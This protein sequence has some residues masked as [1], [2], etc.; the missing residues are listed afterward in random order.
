MTRRRLPWLALVVAAGVALHAPSLRTGFYVDDYVHQLALEGELAL[1]PWAL[2]D[3]GS[4][5]DW[6]SPEDDG[7]SLPWWTSPDWRIRFFRPLSSLA[8]WLEHA[9]FGRWAP[10]Y[11]L[12]SLTLHA[13]LLVL[14]HAWMCALGLARGPALGA[15]AL[16]AASGATLVPVGWIANQNALLEVL[17]TTAAALVARRGRGTASVAVALALAAG[18]VLAKESGVAALVLL[19]WIWITG[20]GS[21]TA[22][23]SAPARLSAPTARAGAAAAALLAIGYAAFLVAAGYG[24]KSAF[25]ATPWGG[26]AEL[27]R[28]FAR[29]TTLATAGGLALVTPFPLDIV[30]WRTELAPA[31][32]ALGLALV[33]PLAVWTA[34]RVRGHPAAVPLFVWL[35]ATLLVQGAAPASDRLLLGPAVASSGLLALAI[36][37]ARERGPRR[38]RAVARLLVASAGV[39]SALAVVAQG[40]VVSRLAA[41]TRRTV[42]AADVGPPQLGRRDALVMQ[43]PS[44]LLAFSAAATWA[45][46]S[47]D[48][49]VR[50][51]IFQAGRR[52]F[53]WTREDER[54]L[55]V[56]SADEPFLTGP[57]EIV[58]LADDGSLATGTRWRTSFFDVEVLEAEDRGLRAVRLR[59]TRPLDARVRL[60]VWRDERFVALEPPAPGASASVPAVVAPALAPP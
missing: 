35:V 27:A 21:R 1:E 48:R 54:T 45:V 44:G 4:A 9:T 32:G 59:F 33:A 19:A 58:Y 14:V 42:L 34:R 50:F 3:F 41:E 26:P 7:G 39:A 28:Y 53:Q 12:A 29:L 22:L 40:I 23:P 8:L 13:L 24:T 20:A 17:L 38:A 60:L 37:R 31:V 25:Y 56:R 51:A 46:E 36:A 15:L 2:Y 5:A 43:A 10:G 16:F 47:G 30:G 18:A 57:F 11:H 52:G 49:D 55:V 6:T